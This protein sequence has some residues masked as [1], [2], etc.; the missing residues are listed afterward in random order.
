VRKLGRGDLDRGE[1]AERSEVV[2]L[3]LAE[4][5][6]SP[7]GAFRIPVYTRARGQAMSE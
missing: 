5:P 4:R 1:K 7:S 2:A 3:L 6:A